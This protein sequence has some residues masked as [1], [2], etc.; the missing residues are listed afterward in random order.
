MF[1]RAGP[2]DRAE[3]CV[4]DEKLFAGNDARQ[5]DGHALAVLASAGVD[6]EEGAGADQIPALGR[7][8]NFGGGGGHGSVSR[9]AAPGPFS[10]PVLRPEDASL[11]LLSSLRTIRWRR[12]RR[13]P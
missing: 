5:Q 3:R 6:G 13:C 1:D 10:G 4:D 2:L 11:H 12:N 9:M 7:R 8:G